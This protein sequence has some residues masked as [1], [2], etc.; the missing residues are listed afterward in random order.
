ML[1]EARQ[2]VGGGV[3]AT[4]TAKPSPILPGGISPLALE[5]PVLQ[6]LRWLNRHKTQLTTVNSMLRSLKFRHMYAQLSTVDTSSHITPS[7][8][9]DPLWSLTLRDDSTEGLSWPAT[10]EPTPLTG[11]AAPRLISASDLWQL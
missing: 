4:A 3:G 8:D 11:G 2:A 5:P 1:L 9:T 6:P 10:C 7:A